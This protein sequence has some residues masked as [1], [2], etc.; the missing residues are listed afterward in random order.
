MTTMNEKG[1]K[2][3][4]TLKVGRWTMPM[5][6][7]PDEEY[8]FRQVEKLVKD[9]YAYYVNTYSGLEENRYL[10][11]TVFDIALMYKHQESAL[12]I[13]P[14]L[15]RLSPLLDDVESAL[16]ITNQKNK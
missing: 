7:N 6:I 16:A 3:S 11:M 4:I 1:N 10:V 2:L 12:S 14:V 13:Q 5:N 15:D 8:T 9:R